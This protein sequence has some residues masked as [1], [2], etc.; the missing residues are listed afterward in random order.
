MSLTVAIP[1]SLVSDIPHLREK[2]SRLGMIGRALA[3]FRINEVIVYPDKPMENQRHDAELISIVLRYMETPQYLRK[4]LFPI[5]PIL[6]YAS[7][8]PPLRTP[9]HPLTKRIAD[10]IDGEYRDGV[11]VK[12]GKNTLV[13]IGFERPIRLNEGNAPLGKRITVKIVKHASKISIQK[14]DKSKI[15]NIYWG[16]HVGISNATLA[17]MLSGG[18]FDLVILTSKYG[19]P[20]IEVIGELKRRWIEAKN[21]LIVF[22]SP[23]Q[24]IR[25]ILKCD[26]LDMDEVGSLVINTIP[27][28]GTKTIRTE[29]AIFA[30]LAVI[31][32]FV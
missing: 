25:E 6:K 13:D 21:R 8:L 26:G 32:L 27:S 16:Y 1:V 30:T 24:G 11:V 9:H 14:Y 29:E 3:I 12:T 2:T 5:L 31:N 19:K 23:K 18:V 28:Q 17:Q 7:I 22:G 10:L 4:R 20:L 15:S